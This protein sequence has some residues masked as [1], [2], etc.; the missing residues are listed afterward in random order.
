MEYR[1]TNVR[2][3]LTA[4]I[5]AAIGM[6]SA[7]S[8]ADPGATLIYK[9]E[10]LIA[11]PISNP[12][13]F[14]M[15]GNIIPSDSETSETGATYLTLAPVSVSRINLEARI[16]FTKEGY[17]PIT[18]HKPGETAFPVADTTITLGSTAHLGYQDADGMNYAVTCTPRSQ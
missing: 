17:N 12:S 5:F 8:N 1:F 9:C 7:I 16:L 18:L 14:V 11:G 4:G 6:S 10:Y 13:Q 2:C 15:T 3:F